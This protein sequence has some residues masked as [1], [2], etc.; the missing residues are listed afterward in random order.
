MRRD[1]EEAM[2]DKPG[3]LPAVKAVLLA[4]RDRPAPAL[5]AALA[6]DPAF[7][8]FMFALFA[9]AIE[10]RFRD[11]IRYPEV[12]RF[13]ADLRARSRDPRALDPTVAEQVIMAPVDATITV[14]PADQRV[15]F[16]RAAIAK[17]VL[18]DPAMTPAEVEA[19]LDRALS[20]AADLS[21]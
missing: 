3:W 21:D 15:G 6:A 20:V 4:D 9:V 10:H 8:R 13:V 12:I 18:A 1:E 17:S 2:T 16:A 5:P 11:G 14:D 7:G 19:L